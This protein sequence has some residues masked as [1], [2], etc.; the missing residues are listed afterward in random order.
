M[1]PRP[2]TR[3]ESDL[4]RLPL[5][6]DPGPPPIPAERG[7]KVAGWAIAAVASAI[8]V[9]DLQGL[10]GIVSLI[11]LPGASGLF[12]MGILLVQAPIFENSLW[13]RRVGAWTVVVFAATVQIGA[14]LIPLL[15][16]D[17]HLR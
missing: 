16:L 7:L 15:T 5:D 8:I 12:A 2:S 3:R 1:P 11:R 17:S 14:S 10:E 6:T 4:K 9:A 13:G